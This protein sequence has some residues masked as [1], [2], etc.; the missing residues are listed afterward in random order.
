M[1]VRYARV[2][3]IVQGGEARV[4]LALSVPGMEFTQPTG[5]ELHLALA[6]A[7]GHFPV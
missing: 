3:R 7:T 1:G 6:V 4:G 2:L 5:W